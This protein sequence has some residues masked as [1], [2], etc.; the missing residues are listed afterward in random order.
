M[1]GR[2]ALRLNTWRLMFSMDDVSEI[3]PVPNITRVPGVKPW[4]MGISNLRGTVVSIADLG[5]LLGGRS[6]TLT[7]SSRVVIVG[8]GEWSYGLLV[9]E[10][11][12]MRHFTSESKLSL[13]ETVTDNL[14]PYV[15]E[16]FSSEKQIWFT[17]N[18]DAL[19]S[20]DTFLDAAA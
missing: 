1:V 3:I 5:E 12:G 16:V 15:T 2:L 14:R 9:D 7:A 11:I 17:F 8:S 18:V 13:A 6:S 20:D 10:V 19:L 4:L